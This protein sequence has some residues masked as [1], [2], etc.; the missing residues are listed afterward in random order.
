MWPVDEDLIVIWFK[1]YKNCHKHTN[2][3]SDA[4]DVSQVKALR[5]TRCE[6][7]IL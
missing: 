2:E 5:R 1:P 3:T 7:R 6:C 4:Y